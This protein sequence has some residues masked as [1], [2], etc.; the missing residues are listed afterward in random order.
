MEV[1]TF[2]FFRLLRWLSKIVWI[3][4]AIL[5]K[6]APNF[7]TS[8]SLVLSEVARIA[9]FI[10]L[11]IYIYIYIYMY[12]MG[13]KGSLVHLIP[14]YISLF[15]VLLYTH[16]PYHNDSIIVKTDARRK[17][18]AWRITQEWRTHEGRR[19]IKTQERLLSHF[20]ARV[21]KGSMWEDAGDRT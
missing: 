11:Y 13:V 7:L 9:F 16:L 18:D 5:S 21:R 4:L 3:A 12:S 15:S 2:P 20:I 6:F 10:F 8:G 14:C 17:I 1:L 19:M